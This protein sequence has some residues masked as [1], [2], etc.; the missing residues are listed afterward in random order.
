M[1]M[2]IAA[3][4]GR[5][6]QSESADLRQGEPGQNPGIR[7][8]DPEDFQNLLGNFWSKDTSVIN[9][10]RTSVQF[11]RDVSQNVHKYSWI[12]I[13]KWITSKLCSVLPCPKIPSPGEIFMKILSAVLT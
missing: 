10:L 3:P 9:F 13:Q 5:Q 1:G 2:G 12:R 6:E 11:F 7:R 8:Q 4:N